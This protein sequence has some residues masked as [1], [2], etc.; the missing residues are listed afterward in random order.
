MTHSFKLSESLLWC[1]LK[2]LG[3]LCFLFINTLPR[4]PYGM[5]KIEQATQTREVIH[6]KFWQTIKKSF[7]II[8]FTFNLKLFLAM[9]NVLTGHAFRFFAL[10]HPLQRKKK[11]KW[12]CGVISATFKFTGSNVILDVRS[13]FIG[14]LRL[15]SNGRNQMWI[16]QQDRSMRLK[17]MLHLL[18]LAVKLSNKI[19]HY[20][21][22]IS[23]LGHL[24]NRENRPLPP[25]GWDNCVKKTFVLKII[26]STK[27]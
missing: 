14:H 5:T 2:W 7:Y 27:N 10:I 1:S 4:C 17:D 12:L 20:L 8:H 16:F 13:C 18:L 26:C 24:S 6:H 3:M 23:W 25:I 22:G 15:F 9:T 19:V 11:G 21:V